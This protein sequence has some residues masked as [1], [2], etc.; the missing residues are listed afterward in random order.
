M[1]QTII[2]SLALL[3]LVSCLVGC[4]GSDKKDFYTQLT[5]KR[6]AKP[7]QPD[8]IYSIYLRRGKYNGKEFGRV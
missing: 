4:S 5:E 2:Y 8:E 3:A 1:K 6:G 7:E